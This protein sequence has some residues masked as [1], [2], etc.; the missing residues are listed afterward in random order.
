T[1]ANTGEVALRRGL[2][3]DG[4]EAKD[5]ELT[6]RLDR[7]KNSDERDR[8]YAFAAMRSAEQ[9]DARARDLAEKIEDA[10]TRKGVRTFVDYMLIRAV[11]K[12]KQSDEALLLIR[13]AEL[14]RVLRAY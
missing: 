14:P 10:E 13:K 11:V 9:A 2:T 12:Q 3:P 5:A 1:T 8:A 4:D 7:A 6:E